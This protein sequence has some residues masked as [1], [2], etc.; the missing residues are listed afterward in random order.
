MVAAARKKLLPPEVTIRE[1]IERRIGEEIELQRD[2]KGQLVLHLTDLS[3]PVLAERFAQ[4]SKQD[5]DK[6][7][8]QTANKEAKRD[9]FLSSLPQDGFSEHEE[10]L[11]EAILNFLH[12]WNSP[13]PPSLS[14]LGHTAEVKASKALVLPDGCGVTFR[15]W[16]DHRIGGEVETLPGLPNKSGT[17]PL[18]VTLFGSKA[19]KK[20]KYQLQAKGKGKG[21]DAAKGD[22]AWKYARH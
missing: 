3:K 13:E 17:G 6:K 5:W 19:A 20:R 16:I 2:S 1:W 7:S 12:D 22:P 11:R 9:S 8:V 14:T 4:L 15:E 21:K 18:Q 10:R